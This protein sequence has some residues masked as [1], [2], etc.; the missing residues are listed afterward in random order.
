[1]DL[2][3]DLYLSVVR[4]LEEARMNEARDT[5]LLSV[6]DRPHIATR[7]S[8]PNSRANAVLLGMFMPLLWFAYVL[9]RRLNPLRQA[10]GTGSR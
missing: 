1:M 10:G 4:S 9:A 7:P 3:R 6:I 5:P 8:S 2:K